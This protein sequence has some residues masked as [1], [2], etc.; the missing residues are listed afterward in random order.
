[1]MDKKKVLIVGCNGAIVAINTDNGVE[2]WRKTLQK[3][4]FSNTNWHDVNI[5]IDDERV[6]AG[7]H[8]Y[9]FALDIYSGDELWKNELKG[10]GQND[11]SLA[12][13]DKSIQ[14]IAKSG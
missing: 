11:I 8:G 13:K 14:I 12:L 10:I 2:I 1:M 7:C 5:L 3:G 9:L 6:Y 4:V